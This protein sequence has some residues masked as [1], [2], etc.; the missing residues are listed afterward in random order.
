MAK[1]MKNEDGTVVVCGL[2]YSMRFEQ[3]NFDER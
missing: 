3:L 1:T 2:Q